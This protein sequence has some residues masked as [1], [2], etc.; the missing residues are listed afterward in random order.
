MLQPYSRSPGLRKK[1]ALISMQPLSNVE[2]D[3]LRLFQIS[4]ET[5]KNP[6]DASS[7]FKIPIPRAPQGSLPARRGI[8]LFFFYPDY[9]VG[10]GIQPD[11]HLHARGLASLLT[12]GRVFHPSLKKHLFSCIFIVTHPQG[13]YNHLRETSGTA[14]STEPVLSTCSSRF[15]KL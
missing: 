1:R 11:L 8:I 2:A 4:A 10:P 9:T 12:A 6:E 3:Y 7:G 15:R 5:T 14:A 13:N